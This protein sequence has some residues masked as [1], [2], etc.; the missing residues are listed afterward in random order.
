MAVHLGGFLLL[1]LLHD[2]DLLTI[3]QIFA[4]P[5]K[6]FFRHCATMDHVQDQV[7]QQKHNNF[8][9]T[10]RKIGNLDIDMEKGMRLVQ[11]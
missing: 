8:V 5:L 10:L 3:L 6:A 9:L 1:H 4:R 2:Q 11:G 7:E